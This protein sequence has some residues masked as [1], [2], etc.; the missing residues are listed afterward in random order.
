M[1][2][3]RSPILISTIIFCVLVSTGMC[4]KDIICAYGE[5]YEYDEM[6]RVKKVT[7]H[8]G[9]YVIYTYDRNGNIT[10]IQVHPAET[11]K[12]QETTKTRDTS[13]TT[14]PEQPDKTVVTEKETTTPQQSDA[15]KTS[16]TIRQTTKQQTTKSQEV[17]KQTTKSQEATGQTTIPRST[18]TQKSTSARTVTRPATGSNNTTEKNNT[19]NSQIRQVK[20][21]EKIAAPEEKIISGIR[22]ALAF[23]SKFSNAHTNDSI[24]DSSYGRQEDQND[25]GSGTGGAE[26]RKTGE[27]AGSTGQTGGAGQAGSEEKPGS[28]EQPNSTAQ[29]GSEGKSGTAGQSESVHKGGNTESTGQSDSVHKGGN[30]ENLGKAAEKGKTTLHKRISRIEKFITADRK[31]Q[32]KQIKHWSEN[33]VYRLVK[34]LL[35]WQHLQSEVIKSS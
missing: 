13:V 33:R 2:R 29:T 15:E 31:E 18:S 10:G 35:L 27:N 22:E 24:T 23:E 30:T 12:K 20:R 4:R 25:Y 26:N 3:K 28:R 16:V 6:N 7:Y 9:S 11:T 5:E 14:E 17:T 1:K 8:D 21:P 32:E 19:G 34:I